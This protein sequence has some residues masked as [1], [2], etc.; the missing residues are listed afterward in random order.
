LAQPT[1][2]ESDQSILVVAARLDPERVLARLDTLKFDRPDAGYGIRYSIGASLLN[3]G[4]PDAALESIGKFKEAQLKL[5]AYLY[6]FDVEPAKTKYPD[7][8]RSALAKARAIFDTQIKPANN[9]YQF[10]QLG[11]QLREVGDRAG[12]RKVFQDCQTL[13]DKLP[14][15]S[16]DRDW[17]RIQLAIAVSRDDF[18]RAKK[19]AAESEPDQLMRLAAEI[20]RHHPKD[21]EPFLA[22][23]SG[24]L[25]LM[26]LRGVANDLPKVCLRVA[27][28]DPAAAERLLLKYA[29]VPQPKTD[30][31]KLFGLGGSFGLNLSKE[32]IE[33]QVTKL[34][35]VCYGLIAEGAAAHDPAVARH[36]LAQSIELLNPLRAGFVYPTTQFY[37]G[38]ALLMALLIPVAERIDPAL[39]REVFWRALSL[40]I[41]MSGESLER[42][43]LDIDTSLLASL[44]RC[45]DPPLAQGL[46]EPVLS[47]TRSRT[48]AG[49]APYYWVIRSLTLESPD[50]AV[51]WADSLCELPWNGLL[52]RD[53]AKEVIAS[54]LSSA[55]N[56][57]GDFNQR[58]QNALTPVRSVYGVYVDRD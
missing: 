46:L 19:L 38:P 11:T 9:V 23:V 33:F 52:A 54:V 53:L 34:K 49:R 22:D 39:A 12:A 51:A 47:R 25:S 26:Q 35:A 30:A 20:A 15:E 10:C 13:L 45:Y 1:V 7:A 32:F 3:N 56:W 42:G 18:E 55:D 27:R 5:Q 43:M 31:E 8:H 41:A 29:R 14:A 4:K 58:L 36:A 2:S 16:S 28:A 57:D 21:V 50:G 6:W 44:V 48:F 40:R 17:L 24:D 37:H